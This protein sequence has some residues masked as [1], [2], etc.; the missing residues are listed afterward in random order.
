MK[1]TS[2]IITDTADSV[3]SNLLKAD[4]SAESIWFCRFGTGNVLSI[5]GLKKLQLFTIVA[6]EFVMPTNEL[7]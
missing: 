2:N 4:F 3:K 5:L 7:Q 6:V 1:S